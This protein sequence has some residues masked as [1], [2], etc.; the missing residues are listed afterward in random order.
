MASSK[1]RSAKPTRSEAAAACL[2][3]LICPK[4]AEDKQSF[5]AYL[6]EV[7]ATVKKWPAWKRGAL[8]SYAAKPKPAD[9]REERQ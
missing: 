7:A 9:A 8:G 1:R 2:H 5:S 3:A 4:C 6:K